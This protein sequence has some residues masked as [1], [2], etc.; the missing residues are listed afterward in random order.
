MIPLRPFAWCL[1]AVLFPCAALAACRP[2]VA[3]RRFEVNMANVSYSPT[4]LTIGVGDT[5]VWVNRDIVPHTATST[6]STWDSGT[7]AQ[8][9]EYRFVAASTGLIRFRCR[10]HPLMVD[11][12]RVQ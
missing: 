6:D 8:G 3:P 12:L 9:A 2:A 1:R 5:V 4:S 11:S 10:F 7:M